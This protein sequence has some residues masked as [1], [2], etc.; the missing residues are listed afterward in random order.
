MHFSTLQAS[1]TLILKRI[2]VI[3]YI[4]QLYYIF[5]PSAI[6]FDAMYF[7]KD[8]L[9]TG[10]S[11]VQKSFSGPIYTDLHTIDLHNQASTPDP[12]PSLSPSIYQRIRK[13][14]Q[15]ISQTLFMSGNGDERGVVTEP[16]VILVEDSDDDSPA[17]DPA[18]PTKVNRVKDKRIEVGS[19]NFHPKGQSTFAEGESDSEEVDYD[20]SL[21]ILDVVE[22]K[23]N[24]NHLLHEYIDQIHRANQRNSRQSSKE[25]DQYGLNLVPSKFLDELDSDTFA[26]D[27]LKLED[28]IDLT[29]TLN[30]TQNILDIDLLKLNNGDEVA[31]EEDTYNQIVLQH[32][33]PSAPLSTAKYSFTDA[34]FSSYKLDK[35]SA[36]YRE[37]KKAL[38]NRIT[39]ERKAKESAITELPK[40]ALGLVNKHWNSHSSSVIVSNYLIDISTR[41]LQTLS[42]GKWLNDNIIDYYFNLIT[43]GL[44][45]V[46][47][48]TTHFFTTLQEKGYQGVARWAKRKRV[49]VTLKDL[50]LV[51]IN[52]ML[53]HWALAT[54]NNKEKTFEYYDSLTSKG[55]LPALKIL[56]EYM[57][58]EGKRIGS[59]IDFMSYE[60]K[61]NMETPQQRNGFDCGVFTC[62]CA[63]FVA[64]HK[65]LSYGQK[66]MKI[67]RRRMAYEIIENKMLDK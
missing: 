34:L 6:A 56:R 36:G 49:D 1:A 15:L 20:A 47:G 13:A 14:L 58:Q 48:W 27:Q 53:T 7:I 21:L 3:V 55:N 45:S 42:D 61:P 38:Q 19:D 28:E 44:P 66:D 40:L 31:L 18:K 51:P 2:P 5:F 67:L 26:F 63:K 30:N 22:T 39:A 43:G 62:T 54:V 65:P 46:F 37:E 24:K 12:S 11:S 25:N 32:Y 60:M 64:F 41:D 10:S 50:V 57:T 59:G 29:T 35:V 4:T 33:I 8:P 23:D 9:V 16:E 17:T 52:I